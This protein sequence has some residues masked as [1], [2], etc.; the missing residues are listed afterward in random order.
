[1]AKP[2]VAP[3]DQPMDPYCS[4]TSKLQATHFSAVFCMRST[5]VRLM[6]QAWMHVWMC[7]ATESQC[8]SQCRIQQADALHTTTLSCCR[9]MHALEQI[10]PCASFA[11]HVQHK[12]SKMPMQIEV[13]LYDHAEL[14]S[15]D[16]GAPAAPLDMASATAQQRCN[17]QDGSRDTDVW[18][19]DDA[20]S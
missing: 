11:V 6:L 15:T 10:W 3:T 13:R 9:S 16:H 17:T 14:G 7:A 12:A 8:C 20:A 1:M 4:C 2:R 19:E 5:I 18:T